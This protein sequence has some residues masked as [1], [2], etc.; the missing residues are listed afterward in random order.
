ME[1]KGTYFSF[2]VN[3]YRLR[4]TLDL[5]INKADWKLLLNV[6]AYILKDFNSLLRYIKQE[7]SAA[8]FD[9]RKSMEGTHS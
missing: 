4:V 3:V 9:K 1:K 2:S 8:V 6:Y 7:G 5:R